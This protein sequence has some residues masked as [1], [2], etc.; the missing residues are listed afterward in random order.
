MKTTNAGFAIKNE[1]ETSST[2][3]MSDTE[4]TT[5]TKDIREIL[6]DNYKVNTA[7]RNEDE[8]NNNKNENNE[9]ATI[10]KRTEDDDNKK[11]GSIVRMPLKKRLLA[12]KEQP[13]RH[14]M[15][16]AN[17]SILEICTTIKQI[18]DAG[19]WYSSDR[20]QF[21]RTLFMCRYR[22]KKFVPRLS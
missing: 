6:I 3:V 8:D 18:C 4:C 19:L 22:P 20:N 13:L 9:V 10:N 21:E 1:N 14:W 11:E 15:E 5:S 12:R 2:T 16:H 7:K 17:P